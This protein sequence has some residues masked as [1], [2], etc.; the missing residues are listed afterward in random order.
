MNGTQAVLKISLCT[1]ALY[2]HAQNKVS[3]G[4]I[5]SGFTIQLSFPMFIL[6][7]VLLK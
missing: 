3:N 4:Y 6:P 5:G 7:L 1:K 2:L